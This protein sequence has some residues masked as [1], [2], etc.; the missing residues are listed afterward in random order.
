RHHGTRPWRAAPKLMPDGQMGSPNNARPNRPKLLSRIVLAEDVE[1]RDLRPLVASDANDLTLFDHE[2][3]AR[4][5]RN[6][7]S[8]AVPSR[9]FGDF[10]IRC[11]LLV[12]EPQRRALGSGN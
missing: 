7:D 12:I 5:R 11:P 10:K 1:I 9:P 3:F 6:I 8:G 4:P 2:C